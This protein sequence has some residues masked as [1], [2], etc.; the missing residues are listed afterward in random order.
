MNFIQNRKVTRILTNHTKIDFEN[1][2]RLEPQFE[3]QIRTIGYLASII[4]IIYK[5][6]SVFMLLM[7]EF[8]LEC[9]AFN[10]C[11]V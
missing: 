5:Q 9:V 2:G 11:T 4:L 1:P 7:D 3:L 8:R 6:K 10:L